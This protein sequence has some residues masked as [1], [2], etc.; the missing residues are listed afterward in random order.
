VPAADSAVPIAWV[1]M[2]S[3]CF[4]SDVFQ[5]IDNAPHWLRAIAS[6]FPLR[7]LADD[8]ESAF[9]P[10]TRSS[11]IHPARPEPMAV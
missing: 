1:T 5:P 2:L 6:F 11:T 4:I 10:V 9:N 7:P 3:L 8:L